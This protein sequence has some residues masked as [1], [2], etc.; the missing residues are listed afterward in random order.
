MSSAWLLPEHIADVL[1]ARARQVETLRRRAIEETANRA[2]ALRE[3][4]NVS[5][6]EIQPGEGGLIIS[7][8]TAAGAIADDW[9]VSSLAHAIVASARR[10]GR[11][12]ST[13]IGS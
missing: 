5:Q 8:T 10:T 1:P 2:D 11:V 13:R 6:I 9:A 3:L 12:T 7:V 4:L